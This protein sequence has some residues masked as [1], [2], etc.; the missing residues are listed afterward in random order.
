M[1]RSLGAEPS[2]VVL[3]KDMTEAAVKTAP[4]SR[5]RVLH[6]A[7]HGLLAGEAAQLGQARAEPALVLSP[8]DQPTEEDDGL[9]TA[10]EV[11]GLKLDADWGCCRLA[12]PLAARRPV[13]RPSRVSHAR[14]STLA[15]EPS[16]SLIGPWIPM[17]PRC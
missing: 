2:A 17:R 6:F 11:A 10:S 5:Y 14:S 8:P 7:T 9:L 16:S 3:G 4:L 13:R 12:T 1:A 15:P